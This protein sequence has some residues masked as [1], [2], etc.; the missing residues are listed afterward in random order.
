MAHLEICIE[1]VRKRATSLHFNGVDMGE[2]AAII[3]RAIAGLQ[4]LG[5]QSISRDIPPLTHELFAT[6]AIVASDF[7]LKIKRGFFANCLSTSAQ[8]EEKRKNAKKGIDGARDT[9][10]H[11]KSTQKSIGKA[12][13]SSPLRPDGDDEYAQMYARWH[14]MV[15]QLSQDIKCQEELIISLK[16]YQLSFNSHADELASIV[17]FIWKGL[18]EGVGSNFTRRR[19]RD[20]N[21]L[22]TPIVRFMCAI[23]GG[24]DRE[25]EFCTAQ[26]RIRESSKERTRAYDVERL[27][28]CDGPNLMNT[29]SNDM[30]GN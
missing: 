6:F 2:K 15:E 17:N 18:I 23:Y 3:D 25:D 20:A 10:R 7:A 22:P 5:E 27:L 12:Y 19:G 13:E 28:M 30:G 1:E 4:A 11:L 16:E 21:E 9:I 24:D 29:N 14:S 26:E 8:V